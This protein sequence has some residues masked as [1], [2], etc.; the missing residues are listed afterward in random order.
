MTGDP[1]R[2]LSIW[3]AWPARS[4]W[5][6]TDG[7]ER[8]ARSL[9]LVH[10]TWP[11]G[12][13]AFKTSLSAKQAFPLDDP[14]LARRIAPALTSSRNR[15]LFGD[16]DLFG[17][18]HL[19][20]APAQRIP[21]STNFGQVTV[22]DRWADGKAVVRTSPPLT[23]A[24]TDRPQPV[25]DLIAGLG[26]I[27]EAGNAWIDMVHV[28]QQWNCWDGHNPVFGY[29]TWLHPRLATV[30][31]DGLDVDVTDVAGGQLI[32]LRVD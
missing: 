31:T 2:D 23:E 19:A 20:P 11:D 18:G 32:V 30:D 22:G 25:Y 15:S 7:A 3:V 16:T 1:L 13:D 28:R 4:D 26:D 29:A 10:Q 24:L 6:V 27:W 21:L 17:D 14:D 12:T 5:T 9:R 8:I